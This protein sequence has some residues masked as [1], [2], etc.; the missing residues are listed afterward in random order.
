MEIGQSCGAVMHMRLV[1]SEGRADPNGR[2]I[3]NREGQDLQASFNL[4]EES[5]PDTPSKLK[6]R[7]AN[8]E[9]HFQK[10]GN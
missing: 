8:G 7:A 6:R 1:C 4:L 9:L 3:P 5:S 10:G 2:F